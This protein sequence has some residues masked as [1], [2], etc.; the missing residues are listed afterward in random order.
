MGVGRECEKVGKSLH[1]HGAAIVHSHIQMKKA[2]VGRICLAGSENS[3]NAV[4]RNGVID[5][6]P[7]HAKP[8]KQRPV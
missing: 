8:L 5:A 1:K 7:L 6:L 4:E 3:G 2:S